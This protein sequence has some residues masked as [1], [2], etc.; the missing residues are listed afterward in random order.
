MKPII[1]P[2]LGWFTDPQVAGQVGRSKAEPKT[3]LLGKQIKI[4]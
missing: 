4:K 1:L 2:C 3:F